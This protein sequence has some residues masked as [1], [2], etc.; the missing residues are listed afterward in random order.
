MFAGP[1]T[2]KKRLA[3]KDGNPSSLNVGTSGADGDRFSPVIASGRI[4][5]AGTPAELQ[6]TDDPLLRQF[7]DGQPDGPIPFDAPTRAYGEAA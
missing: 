4:V 5:F 2:P 3:S 6:S 1:I 7:L